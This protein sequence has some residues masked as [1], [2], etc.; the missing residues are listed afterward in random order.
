VRVR[1]VL[2]ER[3]VDF[4]EIAVDDDPALQEH[5]LAISR[6]NTVPVLVHPN[7]RVEVGFE[8]ETG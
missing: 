8:G 2:N 6:Q 7:G 1:R 4:E 3:K 5:V